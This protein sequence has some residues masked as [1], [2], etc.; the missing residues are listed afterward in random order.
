MSRDKDLR[1]ADDLFGGVDDTNLNLTHKSADHGLRSRETQCGNLWRRLDA[2]IFGE[3]HSKGERGESQYKP[4]KQIRFEM[5]ELDLFVGD[6]FLKA[7]CIVAN[8]HD[9]AILLQDNKWVIITHISSGKQFMFP[10]KEV[11]DFTIEAC[12]DPKIEAVRVDIGDEAIAVVDS[13]DDAHDYVA[14][15]NTPVAR[16]QAGRLRAAL[17]QMSRGR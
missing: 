7:G 15:W 9:H 17:R 16:A 13:I 14:H 1:Q 6:E 8:A 3:R 11:E 12:P 4:G 10:V 2:V 5:R